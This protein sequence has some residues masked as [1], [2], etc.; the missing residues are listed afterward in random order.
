MTNMMTYVPTAVQPVQKQIQAIWYPSWIQLPS[1]QPPGMAE[2][3]SL[4]VTLDCAKMP[5]RK[6]PTMPLIP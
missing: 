2:M 3:A 1:S 4:A 6:R 5:V